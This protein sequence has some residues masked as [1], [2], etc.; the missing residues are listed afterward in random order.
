MTDAISTL[1]AKFGGARAL[2]EAIGRDPASVYRW[3]HP[4]SR[5]GTGGRIPPAAVP[6]IL[7]AAKERGIAISAEE[8]SGSGGSSPPTPTAFVHW[9]RNTAPYI[10]AHRGRTFVIAFPGEAVAS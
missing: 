3:S 6:N 7:A 5:G 2:A 4:K 1:I 10:H 8:L 9:L